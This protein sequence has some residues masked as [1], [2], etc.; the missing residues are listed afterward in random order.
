MIVSLPSF[1]YTGVLRCGVVVRVGFAQYDQHYD[2]W[3][4]LD[5]D[6][7]RAVT[8]SLFAE[9]DVD[10]TLVIVPL[11]PIEGELLKYLANGTIDLLS[12]GNFEL[13]QH[14]FE[15]SSNATSPSF[16]GFSFSTPYY[17]NDLFFGGFSE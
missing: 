9:D 7:C 16:M 13:E 14:M 11:P 15:S 1:S 6:Y 2:Q 4:G 5:V 17:Y 8:L 10:S 12:G 3:S